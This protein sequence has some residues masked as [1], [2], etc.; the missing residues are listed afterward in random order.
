M[1]TI[2]AGELTCDGLMPRPEGVVLL[3]CACVMETEDEHQYY[4]IGPDG[5]T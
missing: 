5:L 2:I 3:S 1:S 4:E